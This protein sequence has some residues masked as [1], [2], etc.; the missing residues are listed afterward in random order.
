MPLW[1]LV[2]VQRH[3]SVAHR[4]V[5]EPALT[6]FDL[7]D[8]DPRRNRRIRLKIA[9]SPAWSTI[10]TGRTTRR[11]SIH[12]LLPETFRRDL[13]AAEWECHFEFGQLRPLPFRVLV[14]SHPTRREP[15][16]SRLSS[17]FLS[18]DPHRMTCTTFDTVVYWGRSI[19]KEG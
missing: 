15:Y 14:K 7:L 6:T 12:I 3:C 5:V 1:A 18:I 2:V 9:I 4:K 11:T 19:Q 16:L 13:Q 17:L 8:T 10:I